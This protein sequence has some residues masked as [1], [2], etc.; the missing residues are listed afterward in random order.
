MTQRRFF[1]P[2]VV[3]ML[4][5][6]TAT[7]AVFGLGLL[8]QALRDRAAA[9]DRGT[10]TA[11]ELAA[12]RARLDEINEAAPDDIAEIEAQIVALGGA[13]PLSI[14]SAAITRELT[15]AVAVSGAS[16]QQL[17]TAAEETDGAYLVARVRLQVVGSYETVELLVAEIAGAPRLY[18]V[19]NL[20]VRPQDQNVLSSPLV[21]DLRLRTFAWGPQA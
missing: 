13:L 14:D 7:C 1:L 11:A 17:V 9:R 6:C 10:E 4:V 12:A 15:D 2:L 20:V 18:T 5:L 3:G 8:P 16:L 19:D 21:A